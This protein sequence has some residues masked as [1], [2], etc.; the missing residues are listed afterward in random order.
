[1]IYYPIYATYV[2]ILSI[3]LIVNLFKGS[4]IN[5]LPV[6][7]CMAIAIVTSFF[8]LSD[9]RL[10]EYRYYLYDRQE[11]FFNQN[12]K[13]YGEILYEYL[14]YLFNYLKLDFQYFR[15]F[16]I[17]LPLLI[18]IYFLKN[19]G[20]YYIVG[21]VFY[22]AFSFYADS[23]L[24]RSTVAGAFIALCIVA[25]IYKKKIIALIMI[26]IAIG[27]HVSAITALPILLMR[28]LKF[29]RTCYLLVIL[30]IIS[31]S[32][33]S[34]GTNLINSVAGVD[35]QGI[36]ALE[37][38]AGY[39]GSEYAESVGILRLST[40]FYLMLCIA[41]ALNIHRMRKL[42]CNADF[43]LLIALYSLV[44]LVG[45][46][47]VGVFADRIFRLYVVIFSVLLVYLVRIVQHDLRVSMIGFAVIITNLLALLSNRRDIDFI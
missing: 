21:M 1:M 46:S 3:T 28:D 6:L 13:I 32:Q 27:F 43:F 39:Q 19:I 36:R 12:F 29:T 23:Y 2:H 10:Y 40:L 17:T 9:F 31:A 8:E 33:L 34:L 14:S 22:L 44:F 35:L 16:L 11:N 47:D 15:V 5:F 30:A 38:I 37:R 24:L 4:R 41:Y 18:K 45:V 20:P 42:T 25:Q 7:V 26:I